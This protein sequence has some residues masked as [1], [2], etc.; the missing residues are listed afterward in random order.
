MARLGLPELLV[1]LVLLGL[2]AV[3]FVGLVV[4]IV[5]LGRRKKPQPGPPRLPPR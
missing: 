2:F 3:G 1:M 5:V 4:L